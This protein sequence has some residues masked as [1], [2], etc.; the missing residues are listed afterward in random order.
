MG[1]RTKFEPLDIKSNTLGD[2]IA[3]ALPG[4]HALLGCDSTIAI[5]GRWRCSRQS[6]KMKGSWMLLHFW[7]KVWTCVMLL[8]FKR[9]CS[10]ACMAWRKKLGSIKHVTDYLQ[11]GRRYRIKFF[12]LTVRDKIP[13]LLPMKTVPQQWRFIFHWWFI[14]SSA[15]NIN[16]KPKRLDDHYPRFN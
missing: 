16:G 12:T 3:M 2:D 1:S 10:G 6:T 11:N 8:M 14:T 7:M 15:V 5:S 9:N 13:N 4:I